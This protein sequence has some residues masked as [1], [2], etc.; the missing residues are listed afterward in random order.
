MAILASYVPIGTK[1]FYPM[2]NFLQSRT[3]NTANQEV[4]SMSKFVL[5]RLVREN[6]KYL[7]RSLFR[8]IDFDLY[9]TVM[10][11]LGIEEK[12]DVQEHLFPKFI[13]SHLPLPFELG[14]VAVRAQVQVQIYLL[15]GAFHYRQAGCTVSPHHP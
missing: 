4:I 8:Y 10:K 5:S 12:Y 11:P 2:L 15:N 6:L 1:L 14:L 3:V 9:T 13:R 7:F